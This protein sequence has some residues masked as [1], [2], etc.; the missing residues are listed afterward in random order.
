[1]N[2]TGCNLDEILYFVGAGKPVIAM[3][4][5]SEA[6][7]ITSYNSNSVTMYDPST[8]QY[9]TQ[10]YAVADATF[11]AAGNI[12]VSYMKGVK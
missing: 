7:I 9:Q 10:S 6:V 12:Y 11:A 3:K 8:G 2:T 5:N 4:N 1:M